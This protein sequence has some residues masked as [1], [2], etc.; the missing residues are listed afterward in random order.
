MGLFILWHCSNEIAN[1]MLFFFKEIRIGNGKNKR[2]KLF[3]HF[4][5]Y[6]MFIL[7]KENTQ[8][9]VKRKTI[10]ERCLFRV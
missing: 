5:E 8:Q 6:Q 9:I 1:L 3:Y 4:N 7:F 10:I 2:E